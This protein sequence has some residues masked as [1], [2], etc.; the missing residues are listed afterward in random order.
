METTLAVLI[1]WLHITSVVVL[2]GGIF[3]ARVAGA[4][5]TERFR[6][7]IWAAVP[8]LIGSGVYNLLTKGDL[9]VRYHM[10]FGIKML[11]VLHIV[12]VAL[13]MTTRAAEEKRT[14]LMGG[15]VATG[16]LVLLLSSYLRWISMG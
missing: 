6:G 4:G 13:I 10:V 14:K 9:P 3:Y 7:W 16:L 11:L 2:I 5:Y 8:V 12:A 1:R 15:V